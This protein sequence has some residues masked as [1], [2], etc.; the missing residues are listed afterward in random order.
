MLTL[1]TDGAEPK[2]FT[3]E[4]GETVLNGLLRQGVAVPNSCRAGACQS[5]MM[6]ATAG[7]P[8]PDSQKGLKDAQRAKGLF[9]A[10][11]CVPTGDLTVSFANDAAQ[12]SRGVIRRVDRLSH[13][14]ARVLID[15]KEPI[16]YFPGQFLNLV[17]GDG[18]VRSYSL[19]SLHS[20]P[21]VAPGDESLELHVRRVRGGQMSEWL[22]DE[23][24]V[25]EPVE[26]HGPMGDC[27]YV[28]GRPEQ[29]I[30]LI[31]TGTGLAPLYAIVRDALRHG[32]TGPI[33]LYHG[34]RG[35]AGLYLVD[36]LKRLAERHANFSYT[37]CVLEG[38]TDDPQVRIGAIDQIVLKDTP[39][40]AGYR[41]FL[42][43]DPAIVNALR[44]KV[45]LAGAKMSDIYADA[46][47]MR[48]T[49]P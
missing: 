45:Y 11:S 49:A 39:K 29:P 5:C 4:P 31:G 10:C 26:L 44:K 37:A 36:E 27:F 17:R 16:A 30:L 15:C 34:A 28:A 46:F 6:Q 48:T 33:R 14:V 1:V 12:R 38:P 35:P 41:A 2:S 18:L 43:G 42:C 3:L 22:H 24:V 25:G 32:H 19:A 23:T 8:S 40:L 9:L 47:V 21:G 13:D 20:P 7:A